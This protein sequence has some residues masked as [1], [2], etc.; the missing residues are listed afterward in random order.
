[1]IHGQPNGFGWLSWLLQLFDWTDGCIALANT[2]MEEV[3]GMLQNGTPI[4]I[5]P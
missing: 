3:W 2:D 4:E 1:M 5:S